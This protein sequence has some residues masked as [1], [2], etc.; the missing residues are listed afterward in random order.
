VFL[1]AVIALYAALL[2]SVEAVTLFRVWPD[3]KLA[4]IVGLC[5]LV[6]LAMIVVGVLGAAERRPTEEGRLPAEALVVG[7][8][9]L[10]FFWHILRGVL[11]IW[12]A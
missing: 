1:R 7:V 9:F 8:A 12:A 5:A 11:L 6:D 4:D 10:A 3:S 2:V